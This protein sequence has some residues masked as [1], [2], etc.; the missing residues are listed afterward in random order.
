MKWI[1]MPDHIDNVT[2]RISS[3]SL[4]QGTATGVNKKQVPTLGQ[5]L[6][7]GWLHE[8]NIESKI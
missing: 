2:A 4:W 7:A 8:S 5:S 6:V 1:C 3:A